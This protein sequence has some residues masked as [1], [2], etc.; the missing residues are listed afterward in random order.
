MPMSILIEVSKTWEGRVID[1]KFPLQKWLGGS[2]HT[3]VFLTGRSAQEQKA[4]IKLISV[5]GLYADQEQD[6]KLSHP[7]LIRLFECGRCQ[8]DNA[9]FLYVVMEYAEEDLGQIVPQRPL[10]PVEVAEMLPPISETLV[11]L[12]Q[13]GYAHGHIKPSN[14]MAVDNQ[15]KISADSLRKIGERNHREPSAYDAPE[16]ATTGVSPAADVWSLGMTLVA[17]LTQQ[18]PNLKAVNALG[19]A[20]PNTIPQPFYGIAERCLRV[21]PKQRSTMNEILGTPEALEALPEKAIDKPTPGKRINVSLI[22]PVVVAVILSAVFFGRRAHQ[23]PILP[24]DT[25]PTESPAP[26]PNAPAPQSPKPFRDNATSPS[27][28]DARGRVLQ[29]ILPDVSQSARMTI[30]GRVKVSVQVSVDASGKIS[31]VKFVSAGPSK[32]FA[33]QA[34]AAARQWKFYPPERNGQPSPSEWL[35]RFQFARTSTQVFPAQTKNLNASR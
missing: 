4:A 22:L 31:Q 3:A 34:L 20:I 1:G 14:I 30:T 21:D 10:S 13:G 9:N 33:N 32:Y 26:A 18:E 25:H 17:V 19:V 11:F 5:D 27:P 12:H 8:I 7:H 16:L 28:E 24:P 35:L 15:L 2:A 6:A 29:Q 23:P